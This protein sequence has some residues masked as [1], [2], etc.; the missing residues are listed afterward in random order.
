M[1]DYVANE[2]IIIDSGSYDRSEIIKSCLNEE[3]EF[4]FNKI[5]QIP[6]QLETFNPTS[7]VISHAQFALG[8]FDGNFISSNE[9]VSM[10]KTPVDKDEIENIVK[11]I[12]L[13]KETGYFYWDDAHNS[14][15]G[16]KWNALEQPEDGFTGNEETI[17]FQT[18]YHCPFPIFIALSNTYPEATFQIL[19]VYADFASNPI[20][21][22][23]IIK[24]G[25]IIEKQIIPETMQWRNLP[26]DEK[27]EWKKTYYRLFDIAEDDDVEEIE[28]KTKEKSSLKDKIF[29]FL[30]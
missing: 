13:Y 11:A 3:G 1:A 27:N 14:L 15:W 4:D 20:C 2:L 26:T 30:K 16:T 6:E 9:I 12:Q 24:S 17:I 28:L 21:G 23:L 7:N 8:L 18:A 22:N 25:I 29:G 19:F 10:C 5:V